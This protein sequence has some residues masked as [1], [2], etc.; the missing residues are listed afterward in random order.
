MPATTTAITACDAV[1]NLDNS[2][3]TLTD[4]S[5]STNEV[6]MDLENGVGE[7]K[8]FGTDWPV[9]IVCGKDGSISLKAVY[10]M[11][12]AEG[13]ALLK[14]WYFGGNDGPRTLRIDVPDSNT[15]SDRYQAEVILESLSVPL[16]ADE[17]NPVMVSAE[18]KTTGAMTLTTI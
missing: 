13:A 18:F 16:K 10:S 17:A 11:N 4:I 9:R 6:Q 12:A 1:I 7:F 2:G 5:G 15:G 8:P 3:G 14:E